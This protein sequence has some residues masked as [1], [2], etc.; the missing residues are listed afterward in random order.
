MCIYHEAYDE[1]YALPVTT[2]AP[3]PSYLNAT[4]GDYYNKVVLNWQLVTGTL[5]YKLYRSSSADQ[6]GGLIYQS[7]YRTQTSY[8]DTT[9][10][11]GIT[12]YYRIQSCIST[13]CSGYSTIETGYAASANT[14]TLIA[15]QL[16]NASWPVN[17]YFIRSGTGAFDWIYV[18][19]NASLVAKLEGMN[20]SSGNLLWKIIQTS[21]TKAFDSVSAFTI[22]L[23]DVVSTSVMF[24]NYIGNDPKLNTIGTQLENQHFPIAGYF[25]HYGSGAYDWVY[26]LQD[27]TIVAK[28]EGMNP[29]TK[30]FLWDMLQTREKKAFSS[31]NIV[32]NGTW[33]TFGA[34]K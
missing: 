19:P 8:T 21:G 29:E 28:L 14:A 1:G 30:Y 15:S 16:A 17:G 7:N 2:P 34:L 25:I 13:S 12:H 22:V 11:P 24:G 9:V 23:D 32:N 27:T 10:T 5:Y 4:D 20:E 18:T 33:I 26:V 31:I 6:V 3:P